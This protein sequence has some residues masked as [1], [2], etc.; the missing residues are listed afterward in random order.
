M[1]IA[2]F[3]C[4][5]GISGDMCLGAFVDLGVPVEWLA[6]RIAELPLTGFELA[7][8]DVR[9][10]GIRAKKIAVEVRKDKSVRSYRDIVQLL[11]NSPLPPAAKEK[12]LAV[13]ACLA[14]A[15]SG[16]HGT[17]LEKVHF[18]EVGGVD[19]VVDIVGAALCLE[20]LGIE[21]IAASALPLGRGYV[22]CAHGTLPLPAP[23]VLAILTDVPVCGSDIQTEL[24]TPTGAA[25][26]KTLADSFGEMPAMEVQ[27][28]G[29]G[30]GQRDLP[31]QPNLLR[32]VCGQLQPD[33]A[34]AE[35]GK[36]DSVVVVETN[37]DDMNPQVFGHLMERLFADGAL[38]VIWIPVYMKKN[39]PG[40]QVQ[41]LC[42]PGRRRAVVKRLLG[43]T[44]AIGVRYQVVRRTVLSRRVVHLQTDLGAL[45]VKEITDLDG[46]I[47][48][49]PEYDDCQ[50]IALEKNITITETYKLID[51]VLDEM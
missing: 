10:H 29:Y 5:S 1:K 11:E 35:A 14:R 30:A 13:F 49:V 41:V 45:R 22:Q 32:V 12:S 31:A 16:V 4:F 21:R 40:V 17:R 8:S 15:E 28:V 3:D 19:A 43:E 50:R 27:A 9:R 23:A 34:E 6:R 25:I 48:R 26:V 38:D 39:R 18:H 36:E 33:L 44:T 7:V 42:E 37:I 51:K 46:R 2:Y 20:R 24:V 47:R